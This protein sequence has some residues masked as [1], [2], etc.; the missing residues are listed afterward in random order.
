MEPDEKIHLRHLVFLFRDLV[1]FLGSE[2]RG[3]RPHS[4]DCNC[5]CKCKGLSHDFLLTV[6][7]VGLSGSDYLY[8]YGVGEI[9]FCD[10]PLDPCDEPHQSRTRCSHRVTQSPACAFR[11]NVRFRGRALMEYGEGERI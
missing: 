4:K 2:R 5:C 9:H 11:A 7:V 6:A 8:G 1:V 10:E 3:D